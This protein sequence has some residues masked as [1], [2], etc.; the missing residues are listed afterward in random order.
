M[1]LSFLAGIVLYIVAAG[2]L[3]L[4]YTYFVPDRLY[5]LLGGYLL[6]YIISPLLYRHKAAFGLYLA[7]QIIIVEVLASQWLPMDMWAM[8]YIPLALQVRIV[9][10]K[11]TAN[12]WQVLFGLLTLVSMILIFDVVSGTGRASAFIVVTALLIY[13]EDLNEQAEKSRQ[14]SQGLLDKLQQAHQQL[15]DYTE[16][17]AELASAREHEKMARELH[18][19]VGQMIFSITLHTQAAGM[20]L[21]TDPERLPDQLTT[22][23]DLTSQALSKMRLLISQWRPG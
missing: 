9:F 23:K 5:I 12:V 22:I 17:A 8:L 21:E 7:G 20:V 19:T 1:R 15:Q 18:D 13:Y 6:L 4:A 14:Q 2:R 3:I 11:R 16:Q 10:S